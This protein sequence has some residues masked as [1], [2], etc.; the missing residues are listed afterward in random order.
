MET[1]RGVF[2]NLENTLIKTKSGNEYF[3]DIHDWEFVSG[4]LP[5][6]RV[7]VDKGYIPCIVSNQAGVGTG[8]VLE[9]DVQAR[10]KL[11]ESEL[12]EYLGVAVNTAYCTH[13]ESFYR[14]PNP[15]MAYFL[16][17]QFSIILR[18]SIM[19]GTTKNDSDFAKTAY[20]GTYFDVD[21][22]IQTS[23]LNDLI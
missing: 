8:K 20:I 12:E 4:L 5:K 1:N 16:A 9:K 7:I 23:N 15:G 21:D 2:I 18:N 19:I 3:K 10:I 14:K 13:L 22:L 6:L 11:V 17:L